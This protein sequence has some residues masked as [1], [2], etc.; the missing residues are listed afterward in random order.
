MPVA[1]FGGRCLAGIVARQR[2]CA[3]RNGQGI[4]G[5]GIRRR[6]A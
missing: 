3:V 5:N 2:A 6:L 4:N 1:L